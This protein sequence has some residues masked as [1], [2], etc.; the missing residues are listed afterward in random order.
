MKINGRRVAEVDI[1]A[2]W[3]TIL[4][5]LLDSPLPRRGDLYHVKGMTGQLSKGGLRQRWALTT[6]TRAGLQGCVNR[7]L[8]PALR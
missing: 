5:A 6:S 3:L 8:I 7:S 4:H 2:S 1:N